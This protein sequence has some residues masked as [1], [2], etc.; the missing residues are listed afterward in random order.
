MCL[1]VNFLIQLIV[2][3]GTR[4]IE[5]LSGMVNQSFR[6]GNTL[7]QIPELQNVG[8]LWL[9]MIILAIIDTKDSKDINRQEPS[10]NIK[11]LQPLILPRNRPP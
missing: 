6:S 3:V 4:W 10:V 5:S 8:Q 9:F 1:F 11:D 2:A 7:S